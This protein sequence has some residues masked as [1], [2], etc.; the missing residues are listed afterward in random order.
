[1]SITGLTSRAIIGEFYK[2]LEQDA[3]PSWLPMLS[4]KMTS[5]QESET[6]KWLG[7][8]PAMR[9]W[10]GGRHAKGFFGNSYTIKNKKWEATLEV[11]LEDWRRDK[12]G[13]TMIRIGELAQRANA[14]PASL[15]SALILAGESTVCYDNA[16]FFDTDHL[17]GN[18]VTN[19]SNDLSVTIA[20]LPASVHGSTTI[21]SVEEMSLVILKCI[22]AIKGFKDNENEPMNEM[23]NSFLVMVPT[24]LFGV[25]LSAVTAGT[26][27]SNATNVLKNAGFNVQVAANARLTWT[28][29]IAVFRTDGSV[30]PFIVQEEIP[31]TVSAIA[32]GSELEFKEDM[33]QYG[34][35]ESMNVGYG[36]WQHACLATM[37]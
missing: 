2:R 20:S 4:M 8:V 18:N 6:Y 37:V 22:Q 21:P 31:L 17:E 7:Q 5:D 30:R 32:E 13:Q 26:L 12:T 25:A 1:M 14:H 15:L 33:H 3:G 9:E 28:A 11:M 27:G 10:I 16:Y 35:M 23:A 24:S 29:Q 34:V 19:Q 36:Y